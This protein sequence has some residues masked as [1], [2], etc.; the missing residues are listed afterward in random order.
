[1]QRMR[2]DISILDNVCCRRY[3]FPIDSNSS[4]LYG[5]FLILLDT[6]FK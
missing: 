4:A 3:R 6:D 1:M 5:I 2:Y